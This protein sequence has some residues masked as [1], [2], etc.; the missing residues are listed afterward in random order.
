MYQI[1]GQIKSV[2]AMYREKKNGERTVSFSCRY[3]IAKRLQDFALWELLDVFLKLM[4]IPN[5][6]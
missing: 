3:C 6:I 4:A 2:Y 5:G 1:E